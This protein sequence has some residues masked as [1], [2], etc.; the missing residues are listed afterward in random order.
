MTIECTDKQSVLVVDDTPENIE[1]L[2][3][4]LRADYV[5]HAA[6][7]GRKGL[8]IAHASPQ[9]DIILL[10][11]MM[12]DM[13]G[14]EVCRR[15]KRDSATAHIP[16]VFI[17]ALDQT[18]D[19]ANGLALGAVDYIRKPFEPVVVKARVRNHLALKRYERGLEALVQ[20]RTAELALTQ[21]V[22]IEAL[23]TLAEYRDSETGGH[24]KRTQRYV[25]VLAEHMSQLDAYRAVLGEETVDLLYRCA[26]L[27]DIGKVA[28]RDVILL[29]PGA[30][31][32]AEFE[33]MKQHV[34]YGSKALEVAEE[35]LG[36][37]SFL[38]LAREL[39]LSHHERWDGTG[40]PHGL[41]GEQIP[42]PG[43]LMAVADVYDAL[44]SRRVYKPAFSHHRAAEI[45]RDGRGTHFDPAIVDAFFAVED[46]F[47][48]I[49]N[50][51]SDDTSS[52]DEAHDY[53]A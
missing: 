18:G 53:V 12:P 36:T 2:R 27:H 46:E 39:I 50:E 15:L 7:S 32:P 19:E 44:I 49:A 37:S 16:V 41:Q 21:Q 14:Y 51:F 17:T 22:T 9:P 30:L 3:Q 52:P 6:V 43:R 29:K 4:L 45:I 34:L 47:K 25:R 24:I 1:L 42:L 48:R 33:E 28:V 11:V 8:D 23:A 10:D 5:V 26:P 31:T 35:R 38:A 13:D 20:A 40:Y